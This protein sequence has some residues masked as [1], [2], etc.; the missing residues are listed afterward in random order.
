MNAIRGDRRAVAR[1]ARPVPCLFNTH[2]YQRRPQWPTSRQERPSPAGSA[3]WSD[4]RLWGGNSGDSGAWDT[5]F[6]DIPADTPDEQIE[7]A[8]QKAVAK[9][10][11]RDEPPILTGVYSAPQPDEDDETDLATGE[12]EV[13][14][15][16][17]YGDED[18]CP[19]SPNDT[20]GPDWSSVSPASA[21]SV[22]DIACRFCG[23]SGSVVITE[24][25]INW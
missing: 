5:D 6:L 9:I 11:W 8:V 17:E 25:D 3:A 2:H 10:K 20:H 14:M 19:A 4:Y 18:H 24:A 13:D 7:A 21:E 22:V 15:D 23:R 12:Q 1:S 16:D